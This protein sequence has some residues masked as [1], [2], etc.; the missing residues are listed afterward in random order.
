MV[1]GPVALDAEQKPSGAR[2]VHHRQIDEEPGRSHLVRHVVPRRAQPRRDR[3]LERRV[4]LATGGAGH[5]DLPRLG[6][7]Q[8]S[9]ERLDPACAR[10]P[11]VQIRAHEV[12]VHDTASA[13]PCDQHVQT[14]LTPVPIQR[15]E[16]HRQVR[17]VDLAVT[18]ADQDHVALVPLHVLQVLHEEGLLGVPGE[19]SSHEGS[20]RRRMSDLV[21]DPARLNV[22]ERR[23]PE[24]QA[25][26][27]ARVLHRRGRNRLRLGGVDPLSLVMGLRA[28]TKDQPRVHLPGVRAREDHQPIVVELVVRDRDQ[29]LVAAAVV[30]A[31]H[32]LRRALG[33]EHAQNALQVGGLARIPVPVVGHPVEEAGRRSCLLSP[34]TTACRPR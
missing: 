2:G 31:Q 9:L 12:R 8:E 13:R 28:V 27:S 5:V 10:P 34:T 3:L 15:P 19:N 25:W 33:A 20:R 6:V 22:A 32:P 21:L 26:G 17:A 14:P 18:D 7:L 24:R 11:Q 30:P 29:R 1:G 16:V 4:G 23:D